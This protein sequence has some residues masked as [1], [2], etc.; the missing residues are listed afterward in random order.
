MDTC[1]GYVYSAEVQV[2]SSIWTLPIFRNTLVADGPGPG[3][4]LVDH[5]IAGKQVKY[6]RELRA[7]K[8]ERWNTFPRFPLILNADGS[9]W[10][11]ACMWLLDR[12]RARPLKV[13]SLNPIAQ[14]LRA[15]R[16]FLDEYEL[17]W[18]DFSADDKYLR[19][20]YIY[21]THLDGLINSG[22]I[23]H[24]TAGGRM[25]IVIGFYRF[26]TE[27][28]RIGFH[29]INEPWVER[30][31]SL[32]YRDN[33]GFSQTKE[34][35]TTDVSVRVP[36]R[37][38]AW[39]RRIQDG[40]ML[41][42]MS[43]QE[44]TV[45]IKSLRTL[46]NR[47]YE[48]M[49]YIS[50]L[51]GARS[52]TVLTLRY[53]DF[54]PPPSEVNQWPHKVQCGPGTG[55][56]TKGDVPDVYLAVQRELYV[57]LHTYAISDRA[58]ARREK[59]RLKQDPLNYLFLTNQGGPYY[60]AKDDIN[61]L[62]KSDE[63]MKRSSAIGQNLRSFISD[64]VIP[65]MQKSL[66]GFHY[67]FHDLRAT[68]G[69]NWVDSVMKNGDNQQRYLWARDQ[70][71]KLMWHRQATVTDRYLGYREHHQQLERAEISWNRDLLKLIRTAGGDR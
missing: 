44:Q 24:S 33:Q 20:T 46:G 12:A 34:L 40:G 35:T 50:L 56:D 67:Q 45:L 26:L 10:E 27:N 59:S 3:R 51:T 39:D 25:R 17:S 28:A 55:I 54:L 68:F 71:R 42:P 5:V 41:L 61:A 32:K 66:P 48:L 60:E 65:E 2:S 23:K 43:V 15:Y 13:S 29:P 52:Q 70:L 4:V 18:D 14:G 49:H 53:R 19:P 9:P 47:E 8:T 38:Y 57:W 11:P 58:A 31:V 22:A 30:N 37:T 7:S 6:W 36:K 1:T 69:M 64:Y 21:K 16:D 62:R 63:L